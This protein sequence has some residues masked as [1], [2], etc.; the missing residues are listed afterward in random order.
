[1]KRIGKLLG[2]LLLL[3]LASQAVLA[4]G[5]VGKPAPELSVKKW[6]NGSGTTL[7]QAKGKIVVVEFWATWCPPCKAAIPHLKE[8]NQKF[9]K[10]GVVFL[11]LTD[12]DAVAVEP[13]M[14]AQGMDYTVGTGS[15]TAAAYGVAGIPHAVVIG[16]DGKVKWEGHPMSGLDKALA[17]A[18]K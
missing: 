11:S 2:L 18:T 12:E 8:L 17:E 10:K 6:F 3:I 15:K 9:K 16:K 5:L 14:K 7:A 1:M 4:E 13:F